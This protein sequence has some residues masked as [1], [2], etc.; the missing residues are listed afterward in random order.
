MKKSGKNHF[1]K[2]NEQ[3]VQVIETSFRSEHGTKLS[4]LL[5]FID[6]LNLWVELLHEKVDTTILISAVK[7]YELG[8]PGKG[9]D[10]SAPSPQIRT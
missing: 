8:F 10:Y 4:E 3:F 5:Q 6:D 7:E 2:L 9:A 1:L